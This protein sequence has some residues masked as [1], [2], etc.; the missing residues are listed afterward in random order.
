[1]KNLKVEKIKKMENHRNYQTLKKIYEIYKIIKIE[2]NASSKRLKIMN[3][4]ESIFLLKIC[5]ETSLRNLGPL[6][7][8]DKDQDKQLMKSFYCI[9]SKYGVSFSHEYSIYVDLS[10]FGKQN[11]CYRCNKHSAFPPH[12]HGKYEVSCFFFY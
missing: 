2:K 6:P 11:Y 12:E 7:K 1:M 10:F 8:W 4:M 9:Y 3:A 5:L